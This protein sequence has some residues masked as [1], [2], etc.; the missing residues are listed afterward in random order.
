MFLASLLHQYTYMGTRPHKSRILVADKSKIR[1]NNFDGRCIRVCPEWIDDNVIMYHDLGQIWRPVFHFEDHL[2]STKFQDHLQM[3]TPYYYP[4]MLRPLANQHIITQHRSH[5][6]QQE[7]KL[8]CGVDKDLPNHSTS[9]SY[10][11]CSSFTLS[12]QQWCW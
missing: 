2:Y 12:I 4:F 7:P 5:I 3:R 10:L 11:K 6:W 8:K 1:T 9:S